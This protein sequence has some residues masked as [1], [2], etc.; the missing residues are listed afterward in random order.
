MYDVIISYLGEHVIKVFGCTCCDCFSVS[1][2]NGMVS[3]ADW[4]SLVRYMCGGVS[5]VLAV[6][7]I[8]CSASPIV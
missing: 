5:H 8:T 2:T 4:S 6:T 3:S 7:N 1:L